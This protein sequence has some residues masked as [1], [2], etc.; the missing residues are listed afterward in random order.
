MGI[1][2]QTSIEAIQAAFSPQGVPAWALNLLPGQAKTES[3]AEELRGVCLEE[4]SNGR[5]I[6]VNFGE[7]A[8]RYRYYR[9]GLISVTRV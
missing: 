1:S 8:Y 5:S 6:I 4:F 9:R 3:L 2:E 7:R